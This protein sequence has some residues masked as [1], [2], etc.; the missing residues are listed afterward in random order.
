[1]HRY[2]VIFA[3]AVLTAVFAFFVLAWLPQ[4]QLSAVVPMDALQPYTPDQLAG[5][6]VYISNGCLYCHSQQVRDPGF[7]SDQARGWGRA[8]YPEDY[9]Y[10][11][12]HLLG[13]MRTGPD[14]I[15]IA[16]RQPSRA[17]HYAHLFQPRALVPGS[18]M[19]SFRFLFVVKSKPDAGDEVVVLPPGTVP[20]G[21]VV[22]ATEKAR[23]L[24]DYLLSLNRNYPRADMRAAG[25]G[26][27]AGGM[28][29]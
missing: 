23:H 20:A 29:H 4:R 9:R 3:G 17:W 10:D 22:V 5:R 15:N 11:E 27:G 26:G 14:L 18:V 24:V 7:G 19:P 13:T 6:G 8:S 21:Q 16:V 1:M 25:V 12:P 2:R 28:A